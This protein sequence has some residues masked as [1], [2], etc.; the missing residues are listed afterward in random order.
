MAKI[1]FKFSPKEG[2]TEQFFTRAKRNF[3]K[4]LFDRYGKQGVSALAA[5]TPRDTGLTASS[6]RYEIT[7]ERDRWS[8]TFLNDDVVGFTV[9]AIILQ[10]GH[11]TRSGSFVEGIDYINPAIQPIFNGI[12]TELEREL[13][14]L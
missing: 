5:A 10:Y 3:I 9:I 13:N 14:A 8:L 2:E 7:H 6:W 12:Q 4:P 1:E 11:L